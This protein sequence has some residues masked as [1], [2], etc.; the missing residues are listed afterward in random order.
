MLAVCS[1]VFGQ[2]TTY[3]DAKPRLVVTC[4]DQI[5]SAG[6]EFAVRAEFGP[7]KRGTP[8]Y[9]WTV[10]QGTIVAGQGTPNLI[11]RADIE[12]VS[13]TASLEVGGGPFWYE[14]LAES[15]TTAVAVR[16]KAKQ[17]DE[18]G[19]KNVGYVELMFD[20]LFAELWDDPSATGVVVLSGPN[21]RERRRLRRWAERMISG[22]KFDLSRITFVTGPKAAPGRFQLWIVPAGADLPK[23]EMGPTATPN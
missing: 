10:S 23:P 11:V 7:V 8:I 12:G 22:R 16:P 5:V 15:C 6:D 17:L 2:T 14:R 19:V 21:T 3:I 9:E 18:F 13:I 1:S 4:P 20:K